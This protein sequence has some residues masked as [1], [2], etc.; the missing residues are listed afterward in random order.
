MRNFS[1]FVVYVD[2]SGDAVWSS[3]QDYPI[4]NVNF[5]LFRKSDYLQQIV[6]KFNAL[7]FKYWGCDNIVL[8]ERDLRKT[9]KINDLSVRSKYE[10]LSGE[11]KDAFFRD[12]HAFLKEANFLIFAVVIDKNKVP[13]KYKEFDPYHIAVY[14]GFRQI[15]SYLAD[16]SPSELTKVLHFVFEKRGHR[17]D[18]ALSKALSSSFRQ[19]LL[20]QNE[21]VFDFSNFRLELM[22]K[23]SNST[24]LQISDL[25]ARPVGN[26]YLLSTSQ[27]SKTDQRVT[28]IIKTKLRFCDFE[29]CRE[30]ELDA[31][32]LL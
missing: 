31:V 4:L 8:H 2:E 23:K 9:D 18:H 3:Q 26:Y 20:L 21:A 7:K 32:H 16:V 10:V 25:N 11:T 1:D 30:G 17:D 22:D 27:K 28:E 24:G 19:L 12:L 29:G 13:L 6:P 14:R 15:H 5:C